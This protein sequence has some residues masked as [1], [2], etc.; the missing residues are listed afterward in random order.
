M[1]IKINGFHHAG[2]LVTDL[3]R[4]CHFY[5]EV[6]GLTPLR[7]PDFDFGGCWYDLG[8]GHQLHLLCVQSLPGHC[9]PA[10]RDRHLALVVEN[11]EVAEKLLLARGYE[12]GHGSGRGGQ[13]QLF[14][15]DPDGNAIELRP[16]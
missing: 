7:R 12:V 11:I 13:P 16:G 5:E 10:R 6:L 4:A 3:E 8:G 15:R 9:D 14:I 2:V 1:P